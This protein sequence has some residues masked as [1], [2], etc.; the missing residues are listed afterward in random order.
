MYYK[1]H[2]LFKKVERTTQIGAN[3]HPVFKE[4]DEWKKICQCRCDDNSGVEIRKP[5]GSFYKPQYHIVCDG[6]SADI[7]AG[8]RVRIEWSDGTLRGEG[9][10]QP[11]PKR[12]N[13]YDYTEFYV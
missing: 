11:M 7:Q 12:T 3:G 2:I 13:Y 1:P 5:D 6:R 8:D 10:V 4:S 9:E